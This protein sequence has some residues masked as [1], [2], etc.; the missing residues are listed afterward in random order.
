MAQLRNQ[1]FLL[2]LKLTLKKWN[3]IIFWPHDKSCRNKKTNVMKEKDWICTKA[4]SSQCQSLHSGTYFSLIQQQFNGV[5]N[6][7]QSSMYSNFSQRGYAERGLGR[8]YSSYCLVI[9]SAYPFLICKI[10]RNLTSSIYK[11][12][13]MKSPHV[14]FQ[15]S[16]ITRDV[17]KGISCYKIA[18]IFPSNF[19]LFI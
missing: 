3:G 18:M 9:Y 2:D 19:N 6:I 17:P 8:M 11:S 10:Q 5:Q 1:I 13:Q 4:R 16:N 7:M 14:T 15:I 12:I